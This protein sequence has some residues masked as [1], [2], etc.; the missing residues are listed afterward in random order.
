MIDGPTDDARDDPT[1][2]SMVVTSRGG[3]GNHC[4]DD[5]EEGEEQ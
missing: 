1:L 2:P 3:C 4:A 5:H